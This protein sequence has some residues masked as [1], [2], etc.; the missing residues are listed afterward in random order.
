MFRKGTAGYVSVGDIPHTMLVPELMELY[1]EA[2]V[3]FPFY[4]A[5]Y[6]RSSACWFV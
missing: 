4:S 1:P 6:P 5:I 3:R 2:K